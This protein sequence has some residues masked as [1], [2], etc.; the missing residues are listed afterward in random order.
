MIR[1]I[2]QMA[3]TFVFQS[4]KYVPIQA[5]IPYLHRKPVQMNPVCILIMIVSGQVD[6]EDLDCFAMVVTLL[7]DDRTSDLQGKWRRSTLGLIGRGFRGRFAYEMR[8]KASSVVSMEIS[9]NL[10]GNELRSLE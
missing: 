5:V 8:T 3:G 6:I 4:L 9:E 7:H 1:E 2:D 10:I